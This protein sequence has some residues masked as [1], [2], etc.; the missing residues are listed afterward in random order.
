MLWLEVGTTNKNPYVTAGFFLGTVK[1]LERFLT[2]I[3]ADYGTENP[4]IESPQIGLGAGHNNRLAGAKSSMEGKS[5]HNVKIESFWAQMR[6]LVVDVYIQ[7]FGAMKEKNIFNGSDLHKKCLQF[8]FGPLIRCDLIEARELWNKHHIRKQPNRNTPNGKPYAL[9][10]LPENYGATN[11]RKDVD[12]AAVD[13]HIHEFS[14][15]SILFDSQFAEIANILMPNLQ[16]PTNAEDA[17]KLY[18][19]LLRLIEQAI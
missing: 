18:G 5:V 19:N 4:V 8:C 1:K 15:P 9:Y 13:R 3:Y 17:L 12:L 14:Q 6:K 11:H 7:L 16:T 10:N 2:L